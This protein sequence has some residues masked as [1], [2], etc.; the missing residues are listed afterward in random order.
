M[1]TGFFILALLVLAT[2]AISAKAD[3]YYFQLTIKSHDELQSLTRLVSID[4]VRDSL[5]LAYANDK[6]L[7]N[8]RSAG[9]EPLILPHPGTLIKPSMATTALSAEEWDAYPTYD[10]YVDMMGQFVLDYPDICELDTIGYTVEGRQLLA[11]RITDSLN[12]QEAEPEVFYTSSMHGDETAGYVLM[13]RLIDYLLS[14]YGVDPQVDALVDSMEIFINPLANPDGTY[15][16]GNDSVYGS[17]RYNANGVDLNRNFPDAVLGDHPDGEA[18][19]PETIAM[20]DFA[21]SHSFVLSANFHGGAELVNYPW[22]TW[23]RDH[24]DKSWFAAICRTYADSAQAAS[25]T[26]YMTDQDN[27]IVQGFFWYPLEGGRQDFMNYRHGCREVTIELSSAKL[28]SPSLLPLYWDYN[29]VS[30]LQ[31]LEN[32]KYGL[33]GVV[34][35]AQGGAPVAATVTVLNHDVD[36]SQVS[37]DADAGDFHRMIAA[38]TYDLEFAA[39]GYITDTVL[40]VH[41]ADDSLTVV[42]V[43]LEPIP[44]APILVFSNQSDNRVRPGDT[45]SMYVTLENIGGGDAEN[46]VGTMMSQDLNVSI[47]Q[48]RAT[49]PT[50][51]F[52]DGQATSDVPYLY[53][54]SPECSP[55]HEIF[56]SFEISLDGAVFDTL[57]FSTVVGLEVDG[58]ENGDFSEYNWRMNGEEPWQITPNDP[59]E[60]LYCATNGPILHGQSTSMYVEMEYFLA[61]DISFDVKTSSQQDGDYLRFL[62]DDEVAGEWSG[63]TGWTRVTFPVEA[64]NHRFSWEYV[65][66]ASVSVGFDKVWVDEVSFPPFSNDND[67]D[68]IVNLLDNCPL[69]SNPLQEDSDSDGVGDSCDNCLLVYNPDQA[70]SKGDGVGDACRSCC[71]GEYAGNTDCDPLDV[72]NLVDITRLIDHIYLSKE[73]LCCEGEGNVDGDAEGIINLADVTRLIDHVYLSKAP[74]AACE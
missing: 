58:F 69:S 44:T 47:V 26:G 15:H 70:D 10:A 72:R 7:R 33:S 16:L 8:L 14:N 4:N 9:Y 50:I 45:V 31:Y 27:G 66:D 18:W 65:K 17:T 74:V 71:V 23:P 13:L 2:S 24:A 32:A 68:G 21:D 52:P 6:Q 64:G 56:W 67:E 39:N 29:R 34:T 48:N 53:A 11:V 59:S 62:V 55:L 46:A 41:V 5:V 40:S 22:D 42:D 54:I 25:P 60:G 43:Q 73:E 49:F 35:D 38:G 36:N 61:G 51:T 1:K 20:M 30:F 19:Q 12:R 63:E 37:A 57:A 28:L 3:E